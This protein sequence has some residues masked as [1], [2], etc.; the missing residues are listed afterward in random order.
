[1]DQLQDKTLGSVLLIPRFDRVA[2]FFQPL[3]ILLN[4]FFWI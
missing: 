1:M 3:Q 4:N 2:R